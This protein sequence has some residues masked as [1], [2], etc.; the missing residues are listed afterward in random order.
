MTNNTKMLIV[1]AA[2]LVIGGCIGFSIRTWAIPKSSKYGTIDEAI[3]KIETDSIHHKKER[4][5]LRGIAITYKNQYKYLKN[6]K[7][8]EDERIKK[9]SSK[10][11][12]SFQRDSLERAIFG[13]GG[14]Q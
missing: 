7:K 11:L 8:I 4:D 12:T 5:S 2:I 14:I 6:Q 3:K 1:F 10:P 9:L 13:E